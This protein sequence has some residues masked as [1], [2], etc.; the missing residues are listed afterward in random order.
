MKNLL[1]VF[2]P[3]RNRDEYLEKTLE[4]ITIFCPGALIFV[5]NCSS[6]DKILE[7]SNV[8]KSFEN[9][10]EIIMS[11]DPGLSV[12]YNKLF[13]ESIYTPYCIWL[14]DD[15][16]F[17]KSVYNLLNYLECNKNIN[18]VGLPMIDNIDDLPNEDL[19]WSK[20]EFGCALWLDKNKTRVAH[21]GILRTAYFKKIGK[22]VIIA[23][24]NRFIDRFCNENTSFSQKYWPKDG[25]YLYHKR[26]LDD[27][28]VNSIVGGSKFRFPSQYRNKFGKVLTT[29]KEREK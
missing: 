29:A 22:V 18:L 16:L 24:E 8:I 28:R 4:M 11:P 2:F 20:D 27:T 5:A 26:L 1:S 10:K 6:P 13:I 25:A 15:T 9:T 12:A 7:T 3:T 17:L 21:Y 14:A 19:P 23:D